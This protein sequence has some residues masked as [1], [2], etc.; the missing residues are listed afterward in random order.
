M[1]NEMEDRSPPIGR[2]KGM[3]G[4]SGGALEVAHRIQLLPVPFPF[5]WAGNLKG[6]SPPSSHPLPLPLPL[7]APMRQGERVFLQ[8]IF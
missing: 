4:D 6:P 1:N 7:L 5:P 3:W 2:G 8:I